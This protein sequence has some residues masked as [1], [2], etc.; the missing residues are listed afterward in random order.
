MRNELATPTVTDERTY[1]H[2]TAFNI[3]YKDVVDLSVTRLNRLTSI[4][5]LRCNIKHK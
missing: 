3:M 1:G 2:L 4:K 5:T